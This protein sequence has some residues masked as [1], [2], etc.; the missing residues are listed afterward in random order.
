MIGSGRRDELLDSALA[1]T[2]AGLSPEYAEV[3]VTCINSSRLNSSTPCPCRSVLGVSARAG[4][5][6]A[7]RQIAETRQ[8]GF[9]GFMGG[10]LRG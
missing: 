10:N 4:K 7:S 1:M 2:D 3:T 8:S 6:P 9:L 5:P